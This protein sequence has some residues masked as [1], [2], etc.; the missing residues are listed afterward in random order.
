[1]QDKQKKNQFTFEISLSVLNHLGRKL[2]RSFATVIGEAISNSWDADAKEVKLYIDRE[3]NNFIIKDDGHGMNWSDFQHKFL[4]VGYSKRR[5]TGE[6]CSPKGRPYIGRKGIG[7]LA[8]LS[9]ADK[10]TVISKIEGGEYV[11]GC[12]NNSRLDKAIEDDLE[13]SQYPLEEPNWNIFEEYMKDHEKGTIIH[14]E[15]MKEGIKHKPE[16]LRKIIALYFRFALVDKSFDMFLNDKK[17]TLKD[18]E[19]L[20]KKTQFVWNINNIDDPYLKE[21]LKHNLDR[22]EKAIKMEGN[23]KGFI[24]SVKEPK[25]RKIYTT[26]EKV[27]IDL[28]VNGRL[29]EKNIMRHIPTAVLVESYLYGQIHFDELDDEEDRFTSS[30]ENI[31]SDDPKYQEFLK[32]LKTKLF[33]IFNEWD[34][35]RLELKEE[36]DPE[37]KRITRKERT[38]KGLYNAVSEYYS[39]P[40]GVKLSKNQKKVEEWVNDLREDASYNF[41]SYAECFI[42]ENLIREYVKDKKIALDDTAKGVVKNWK[43]KESKNKI[44]GNLNIQI[45]REFDD[46]SYLDMTYLTKLV[47]PQKT[48]NTLSNDS[49]QYK[50]IRDALMH[51]SLLTKEA[52]LKLTTVYQNM[53]ER[54]KILLEKPSAKA[55]AN[56][57]KPKSKH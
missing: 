28:F 35:W 37:N 16:Y 17:I 4:K 40:K 25:N 5:E 27:T 10:I 7:K 19:D 33:S 2:Y 3:N 20:A 43:T 18:L 24:A 54:V 13:P 51:T 14:F 11:G 46:L 44:K 50:P 26:D 39:P 47:D 41:G 45:R 23:V 36:G 56:I 6:R 32:N 15:N 53:K 31:V 8:L 52:K 12:I 38:S 9:S 42:S 57:A 30:R 48:Q 21:Y 29:R 55:H 34:K 1:M 22:P 49:K